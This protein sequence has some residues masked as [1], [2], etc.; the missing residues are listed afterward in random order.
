M[1]TSF[2]PRF[3]RGAIAVTGGHVLWVI[4]GSLIVNNWSTTIWDIAL[5]SGG[6][7]W[8]WMHPGLTA[9]IVLGILQLLSLTI[10]FYMSLSEPFGTTLHKGLTMHCLLD[11][12]TIALLF[13]GYRR[14]KKESTPPSDTISPSTFAEPSENQPTGGVR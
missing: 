5:F 14:L 6:M 13:T 3:F 11:A 12:V 9:A 1:K 8:L 7:I 2:K 10:L 4:L